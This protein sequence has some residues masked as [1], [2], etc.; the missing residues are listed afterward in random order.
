M[1]SGMSAP[2]REQFVDL[3]I[4]QVR[5]RF[6]LVKLSRA[7]DT[8]FS[9]KINGHVTSLENLYRIS[10]LNPDEMKKNVDRWIVELIRAAEGTPDESGKYDDVKERVLPMVLGR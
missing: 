10:I 2:T 5:S 3:V 7:A 4:A 8:T 1:L 9:L 6:P